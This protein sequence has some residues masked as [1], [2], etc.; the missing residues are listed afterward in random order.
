MPLTEIQTERHTLNAS[1]LSLLGPADW[2]LGLLEES[3]FLPL[4]AR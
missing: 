1:Y 2:L 3:W 4:E